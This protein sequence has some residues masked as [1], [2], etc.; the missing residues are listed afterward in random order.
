MLTSAQQRILK[1]AGISL[2][3]LSEKQIQELAVSLSG[4]DRLSEEQLVEFLSVANALYRGGEQLISDTD[5]DLVFLAELKNR[6]PDHPYLQQVEPEKGF[7]GKKARLPVQMLSTEKAYSRD[8]V[9]QWLSRQEAA[10]RELKIDFSSVHIRVTPKLDGYAA[11]DSGDGF[12]TRGDGLYGT[13]ISRVFERGLSVAGNGTRGQGAGEIVV[14]REYFEQVLSDQFDNP[15][16]FQASILAEKN[17]SEAAL[18][19]IRVGAAVFFPFAQLPAWEGTAQKLVQNLEKIVEEIQERVPYD[20][21]GAVLE[22]T[23]G[24]IREFMSSTRHHHKWQIAFKQNLE[25]AEVDVLRV[26]PQTGRTGRCTPVI[27]FE[28]VQLSGANLSRATAHNYGRVRDWGIGPGAR[29]LIVRSGLVIPKIVKM[30]TPGTVTLPES[31]PSCES[32]LAWE[33]S[34]A[35]GNTAQTSQSEDKHIFLTCN[36]PE[37]PAQVQG[38]IEFFFHLVRNCDGFGPENL[39]I[40][41]SNG[42]SKISEVYQL[43]VPRLVEMGFGEKTAQNLVSE[44]ERSRREVLEDWRFL[45]AFG[46]PRLGPGNCEKVLEQHPLDN[47]F[48]LTSKDFEKIP[49]FSKTLAKD[50]PAGLQVVKDEVE[51]LSNLGFNLER[52]VL[53]KDRTDGEYPLAGKTFVFTGTLASGKRPEISKKAKSLGGKVMTAVSKATDYLVCGANVGHKK[54]SEAEKKGVKVITEN[55]FLQMIGETPK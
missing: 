44:L 49:G 26:V 43:T 24:T 8:E 6:N 28:P 38:R 40:I 10:A 46:V 19:A 15:R 1:R 33:Q 3:H 16:N 30:L 41:C 48:E 5:Y 35:A 36:N 47:V 17:P 54:T 37:C 27:E 31:C 51:K 45:A 42:I 22:V 23:D 50:V 4:E 32:S 20:T 12:F 55:E 34:S 39:K 11:Y 13:E 9:I 53:L 7:E 2:R 18:E 14:E 21:D 25:S 29:V 52:T